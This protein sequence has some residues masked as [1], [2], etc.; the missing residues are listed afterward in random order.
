MNNIAT[1]LYN[2]YYAY[3]NF[4]VTKNEYIMHIYSSR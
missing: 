2:Y 1:L 3:V 4:Y